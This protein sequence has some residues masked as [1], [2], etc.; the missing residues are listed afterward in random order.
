M[1]PTYLV[2]ANRVSTEFE[3]LHHH[4]HLCSGHFVF[5]RGFQLELSISHS[6][7][8]E[9]FPDISLSSSMPFVS[10]SLSHTFVHINTS[11][12]TLHHWMSFCRS[13]SDNITSAISIIIP[14]LCFLSRMCVAILLVIHLHTPTPSPAYSIVDWRSCRN[15]TA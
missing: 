11:T 3:H 7:S 15:R 8:L 10:P 4:H 6:S 13:P 9:S 2:I 14:S 5:S 12:H 1:R